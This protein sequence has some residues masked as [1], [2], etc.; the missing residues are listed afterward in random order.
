MF[1][2][3]DGGTFFSVFFCVKIGRGSITS[4]EGVNFEEGV[5]KIKTP[6]SIAME[7]TTRA[8]FSVLI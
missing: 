2:I 5:L 8:I 3:S 6:P 1:V 7:Q 4:L